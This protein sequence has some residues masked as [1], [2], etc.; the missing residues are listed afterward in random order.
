MTIYPGSGVSVPDLP[1]TR[2]LR[3]VLIVVVVLATA[4]WSADQILAVLVALLGV[5]VLGVVV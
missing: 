4:G 5:I 3:A 2:K 1:G